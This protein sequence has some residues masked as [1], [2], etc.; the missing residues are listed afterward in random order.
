MLLVCL[1]LMELIGVTSTVDDMRITQNFTMEELVAS[2]TAKRMNI[3]NTPNQEQ[4]ERL[5]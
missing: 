3:D 5:Y 4:E 1:F 2:A